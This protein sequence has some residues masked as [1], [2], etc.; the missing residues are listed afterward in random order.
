[1]PHASGLAP[2]LPTPE[3]RL[4]ELA[5]RSPDLGDPGKNLAKNLAGWR[6]RD[7]L[8]DLRFQ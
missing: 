4:S 3:F 6:N 1:M 8:N 5:I 7:V 2:F